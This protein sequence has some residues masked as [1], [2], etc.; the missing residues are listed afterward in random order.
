MMIILRP[1]GRGNWRTA[2]LSIESDRVQPMLVRVGDQF[3]FAG[4]IWRV[5][6]V[7]P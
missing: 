3:P 1:I 5:V 4:V 7:L 6:R 2:Q